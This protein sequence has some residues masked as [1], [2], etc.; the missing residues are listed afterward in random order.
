M[1]SVL[2]TVILQSTLPGGDPASISRHYGRIAYPVLNA[3]WLTDVFHAPWYHALMGLVALNILCATIVNFSLQPARWGF[4]LAHA[5]VLLVLLG[6]LIYFA[7]G[8]K[9]VI[10]LAEGETADRYVSKRSR[11]YQALPF[12]IKLNRFEIDY[13]PA[14]MVFIG[15]DNQVISVRPREGTEAKLPWDDTRVKFE[16][17]IGNARRVTEVVRGPPGPLNPAAHF[18]LETPEGTR[19]FWRFALRAGAADTLLESDGRIAVA[20]D[21]LDTAKADLVRVAP[22]LFV[23]NRNTRAVTQVPA[24]AG[25]PFKL[26][27]VKV[28]A[29]AKILQVLD[30]A[31][32]PTLGPGLR[33]Q[34]ETGGRIEWRHVFARFPEFNPDAM[35]GT[36]LSLPEIR[37]V[38]YRPRTVL[39]V[40]RTPGPAYELRLW[41][42]SKWESRPMVPGTPVEVG[43]VKLTLLLELPA[44]HVETRY[45]LS[46]EPTRIEAVLVTVSTHSGKPRGLWLSTRTGGK[47]TVSDRLTL[48][49]ISSEDVREYRSDVTLIDQGGSSRR[50]TIRVNHPAAHKGWQIFQ[51][52]YYQRGPYRVSQLAVSRDPGLPLA[53]V[54]LTLLMVGVFYAGF[55]KPILVKREQEP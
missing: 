22:T 2:G 52:S 1:S 48:A 7:R 13:Y 14:E 43:P 51:E 6:G 10:T 37:F 50:C 11:T 42:R 53:Y 24:R 27:G 12:S 4:L 26:P 16:R 49:Y 35:T 44:A 3:L 55:V 5:G 8:D 17:V 25:E 15:P 39:H 18:K 46:K 30:D 38:Y 34:L 9:G 29:K 20:F 23:I 41:T 40:V 28:P 31:D 32:N 19:E 33:I 45:D 36:R 54:G 47:A 21:T